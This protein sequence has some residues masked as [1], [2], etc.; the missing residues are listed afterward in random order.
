MRYALRYSKLAYLFLLNNDM[1]VAYDCLTELVQGSEG[2]TKGEAG[3]KLRV[4]EKTYYRW[5]RE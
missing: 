1:M 3:R 2:D 5:R 4:T